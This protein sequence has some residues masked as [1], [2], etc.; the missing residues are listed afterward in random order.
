MKA[1]PT[2]CSKSISLGEPPR[3]REDVSYTA[4]ENAHAY[5]EIGVCDAPCL[6]VI[7]R[8][9]ESCRAEREEAA[10]WCP[11]VNRNEPK[12]LGEMGTYRGAGF[13]M[14][15]RGAGLALAFSM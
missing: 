3:A 4:A 15:L 13:A 2:C 8:D 12:S 10:G 1:E 7:Q 14:R 6:E 5:D 11:S 9:H